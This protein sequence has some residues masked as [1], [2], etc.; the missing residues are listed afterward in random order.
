MTGLFKCSNRYTCCEVSY[1]HR[2]FRF[3]T[4]KTLLHI[5]FENDS[6]SIFLI[7]CLVSLKVA[8]EDVVLSLG[9]CVLFKS[10]F[11]IVFVIFGVVCG[12]TCWVGCK[13]KVLSWGMSMRSSFVLVLHGFDVITV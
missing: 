4:C 12:F 3:I 8:M 1:L 11:D 6:L 5:V 9:E 2:P 13:S 7:I 10:V